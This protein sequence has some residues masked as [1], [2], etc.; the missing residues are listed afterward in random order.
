[1]D[2]N[3]EKHRQIEKQVN[4]WDIYARLMPPMFL[5]LSLFL[6][7]SGYISFEL[8]F[9]VGLGLFACT[10]VIWWF[11]TIFTIKLLVRTLNRA[12]KNL[13][14]VKIEFKEIHKQV[15][16]LRDETK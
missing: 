7:W 11:W 8:A 2:F 9:W 16:A 3:E 10:A 12:G 6:V 4:R 1:M 15:K 13:E 5:V 14:E